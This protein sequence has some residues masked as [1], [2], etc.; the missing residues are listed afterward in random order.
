MFLALTDIDMFV[1]PFN[2]TMVIPLVA[3]LSLYQA[4]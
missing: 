2:V 3:G 4:V 1:T